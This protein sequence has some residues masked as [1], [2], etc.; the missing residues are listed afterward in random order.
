MNDKMP[1]WFDPDDHT[2]GKQLSRTD[3]TSSS[4]GTSIY[5]GVSTGGGLSP[6]PKSQARP[7]ERDQDI[8]RAIA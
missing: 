3:R 8:G 1:M 5:D 2:V 6:R 7:W 4:P